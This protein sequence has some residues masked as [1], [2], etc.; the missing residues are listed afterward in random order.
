MALVAHLAN[1]PYIKKSCMFHIHIVL[2][3]NVTPIYA[4]K[5]LPLS[6]IVAIYQ[7]VVVNIHPHL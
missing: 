1:N 5:V 4:S 3:L 7:L 2:K 6:T